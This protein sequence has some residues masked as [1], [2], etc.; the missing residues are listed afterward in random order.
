M[1]VVRPVHV[2]ASRTPTTMTERTRAYS[3]KVWPL[4]L[5]RLP[6][7]SEPTQ[8]LK[9]S[10]MRYVLLLVARATAALRSVQ[11]VKRAAFLFGSPGRADRGVVRTTRSVDPKGRSR[12]HT[13]PHPNVAGALAV[14][15]G[16]SPESH[17]ERSGQHHPRRSTGP[18]GLRTMRDRRELAEARARPARTEGARQWRRPPDPPDLVDPHLV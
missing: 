10:N 17:P 15:R 14:C 16:E 7:S 13:G 18:G 11:P 9:R 6:A 12:R 2:A 4:S 1:A 5:L 8:A 3:T